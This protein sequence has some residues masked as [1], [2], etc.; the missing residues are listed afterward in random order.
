MNVV[1]RLPRLILGTSMAI[2][3]GVV[4]AVAMTAAAKPVAAHASTPGGTINRL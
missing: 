2:A 4:G 1:A 3:V